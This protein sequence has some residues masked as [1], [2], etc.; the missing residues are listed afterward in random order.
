ML[1]L[2]SNA[3]LAVDALLHGNRERFDA[4][5][6]VPLTLPRWAGVI[7]YEICTA[8]TPRGPWIAHVGQHP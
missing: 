5:P 7:Q 8:P 1:L 4:S 3:T 2:F 6:F